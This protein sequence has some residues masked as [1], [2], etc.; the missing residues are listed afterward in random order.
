VNGAPL[1]FSNRWP[2]Y[3]LEKAEPRRGEEVKAL[4]LAKALDA[5]G[6]SLRLA[7]RDARNTGQE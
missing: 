2:Q 6:E 3:W 1:V 7:D 5:A 4:D